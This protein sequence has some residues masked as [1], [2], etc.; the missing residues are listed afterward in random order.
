MNQRAGLWNLL[1]DGEIVAL[2][3]FIPGDVKI[4]VNIAYLR[5]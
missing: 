4:T 5:H 3:G 1:H 2:N